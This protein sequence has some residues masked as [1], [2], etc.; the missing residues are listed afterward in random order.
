MKLD[1]LKIW[2]CGSYQQWYRRLLPMYGSWRKRQLEVRI[3]KEQK[4]ALY[5]ITLCTLIFA[6]CGC[7]LLVSWMVHG[8][9]GKAELKQ[10]LNNGGSWTLHYDDVKRDISVEALVSSEQPDL[11]EEEILRRARREISREMLGNNPDWNH[12]SGALQFP[13][14]LSSGISVY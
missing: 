4:K 10:V 5:R 7:G 6:L 9:E 13:N 14:S 2:I 1:R 11:E 3:Q 8:K 12:V